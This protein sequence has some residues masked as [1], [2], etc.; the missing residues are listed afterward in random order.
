MNEGRKADGGQTTWLGYRKQEKHPAAGD[1]AFVPS[2]LLH[3]ESR[4]LNR[5]LFNHPALSLEGGSLLV[6]LRVVAH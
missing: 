6:F 5:Q 3:F 1:I 2:L 4:H